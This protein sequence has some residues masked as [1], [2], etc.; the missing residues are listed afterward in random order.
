[1]ARTKKGE[2]PNKMALVREAIAALG[3]NAKP[4]A[5]HDHIL[6]GGVDIP[7]GMISSYKSMIL[8][9][10]GKKKRGPGRPP[11]S[12]SAPVAK[13]SGGSVSID[14]LAAI[15]SLVSKMG[16]SKLS[17]FIKLLSN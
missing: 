15:K 6:A 16:A 12:A 3:P 10:G 5:M 17:D 8:K 7:T 13:G 1:M 14:D 11:K 4:K 9:K 2:G